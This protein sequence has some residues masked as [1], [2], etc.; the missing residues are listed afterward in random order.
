MARIAVDMDE[1][2]AD[3]LGEHIRRYNR[4]FGA[5][6]DK[7]AVAGRHL[8]DVIPVE[9]R[10]AAHEIV[11]TEDFFEDLDVM[12]GAQEVLERLSHDHE[13]FI[14]TAAMEV[15][16]SFA[17]KYRWLQ[18]HFPFISPMN[19]VFCGNK[20]IIAADYLIDDN[21]RHFK[22]FAGEGILFD[23]HHNKHVTGYRR[24]HNW[25]EVGELFAAVPA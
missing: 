4:M 14:A 20:Y 18:R 12:P 13:I 23:A 2:V 10:R 7:L 11:F 9:H 21:A 1:V 17:S 6:V 22:L 8:R 16:N 19:Y 24:V 5:N 25:L 3:A 15:P